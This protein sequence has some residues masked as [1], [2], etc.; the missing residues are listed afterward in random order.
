MKLLLFFFRGGAAMRMLRTEIDRCCAATAQRPFY[1]YGAELVACLC[2]F[3]A[4]DPISG[5]PVPANVSRHPLHMRVGL[6]SPGG[7]QTACAI[8]SPTWSSPST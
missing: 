7:T 5:I 2:I 3:R 6:S 1:F 4:V 8:S